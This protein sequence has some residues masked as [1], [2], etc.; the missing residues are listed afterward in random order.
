MTGRPAAG[1]NERRILQ[2]D[3]APHL[4]RPIDLRS[5]TVKNRI[6]MSPMCQYSASDGLTDDWHFAHL[7]A[8]AVGGAGIVCV[9]ATH[10]EARGRITHGCVG[11]W[12]DAQRDRLARIAEFVAARGAVPAIQLAHAGRKGSVSR[13]WQGTK[14]LKPEEGAWEVI[15]PSALPH[16]PGHG[17]PR[18]VDR[19]LI[20]EVVDAFA[21]ATRRAREAGFQVI[22]LHS[23]HGYLLHEF[24]SPLSNRRDDEFGGSFAN[25]TRLLLQT[26]D[27]VR[28]EWP[29]Q[30]PLFVRLSITDWMPGGWDVADSIELCRLLKA[31]GDVD[32]VDCSSGGIDPRQAPPLHPGYLV[33]F[34]E[35]IRREAGIATAAVGLIGTPELAEEAIANR[36]ADFVV[37]GRALLHDPYWPLHAAKA[38]KAAAVPWPVQYERAN[39]F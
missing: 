32:V 7:A 25:R 39:I 17:V 4:F 1:E 23:A 30:L 3:P 19:G 29:S 18:A 20:A 35:T 5:I 14:P 24:L 12:N 27:A 33:P 16:A 38:L 37:L 13:P 31:R 26:L 10:V 6:M 9:E 22:E 11:L 8:R 36:R 15:G 2:R 28:S 21:A 34:A